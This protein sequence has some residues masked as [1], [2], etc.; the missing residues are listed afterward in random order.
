M[1]VVAFPLVNAGIVVPLR[2][3]GIA[4]LVVILLALVVAGIIV[5]RLIIVRIRRIVPRR[6]WVIV[7]TIVRGA[8]GVGV[9]VVRVRPPRIKAD[10]ED[11]PRAINEAALMT[12]PPMVA[13]M[14]PIPMPLP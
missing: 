7:T 3:I 12:I 8:I 14:V 13:V 10:I 11:H 2:W 9:R 1:I 5:A 6:I 4:V